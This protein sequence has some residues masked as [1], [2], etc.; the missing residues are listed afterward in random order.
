MLLGIYRQVMHERVVGVWSWPVAVCCKGWVLI[1]FSLTHI[2]VGFPLHSGLERTL[3]VIPAFVPVVFQGC[4]KIQ[5]LGVCYLVREVC[6]RKAVC[7]IVAFLLRM[8]GWL[9]RSVRLVFVIM[10]QV[11]IEIHGRVQLEVGYP[12]AVEEPCKGGVSSEC[13]VPVLFIFSCKGIWIVL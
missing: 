7:E 4:C 11:V 12:R 3:R 9:V 2:A 10:I 5:L 1:I 6:Q 8:Y 13:V